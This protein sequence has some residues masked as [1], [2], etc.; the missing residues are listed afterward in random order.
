MLLRVA[1]DEFW[2]S[3]SDSDVLLWAQGV[4]SSG[5]FDVDIHEIDVSP[6]QIQGPKSAPLM[7]KMFGSHVREIPYYH[8]IHDEL[9]GHANVGSNI[10]LAIMPP[11]HWKRGTR[12]KVQLPKDG[13]VDAEVVPVP[14]FDPTKERPKSEL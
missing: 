11:S 14:F 10:A 3:I 5:R 6:V 7:E 13:L 1:E 9:N 8:L 12:V 4:N 2:F